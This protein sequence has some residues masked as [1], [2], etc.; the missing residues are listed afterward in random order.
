MRK[1][2]NIQFIFALLFS[3]VRIFVRLI[4]L[5]P[6][7][8]F[9]YQRGRSCEQGKPQLL[10]LFSQVPWCGVWQR[11]QEQAMGL[12]EY[13]RICYVSPLQIHE[14]MVRYNDWKACIT[15][16]KGQGITIL[17]PLIFSGHYRSGLV[18]WLNQLVV[19][20]Y[21]RWVLRH[22]KSFILLTN[23]PFSDYLLSSL[24]IST[25]IYDIIDDFIA[26]EWAPGQGSQMEKRIL[27]R[28]DIVFT[29]TL[30]LY[31]RKKGLRPDATFIPCGVR[32]DLFYRAYGT[33]PLAEPEDIRGLP[34]PILGY[35]GTLSDRIDDSIIRALAERFRDASLVLIGPVHQSLAD[36]PQAPNI[37]YLG[38]KKHEDLP[39]Y[40]RHFTIALLPFRLTE[41]ALAVNPVK[42][43]EYLAAGCV[44]VSTTIPDV[45]RFYSDVVVVASSREDFIEKTALLLKTDNA[46]RIRKGIERARSESWKDMIEKMRTI[47]STHQSQS[48]GRV[49]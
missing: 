47:I 23:S 10:V 8:W 4:F 26:F 32:F 18:R 29:G 9:L 30:T 38:L 37:H 31:E 14:P 7:S 2:V 49:A 3:S 12:A 43:L 21:L 34:R 39:A 48:A 11:P 17:S 25:M 6:L 16:E 27:K 33:A 46:E 22:E 1:Q 24:R 35:M 13:Y 20:A 15:M 40:L 5:Y 42:T 36:P 45:V 19:V 28:A 44:V 41:A